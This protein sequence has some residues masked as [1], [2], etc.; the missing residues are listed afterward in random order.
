M[1]DSLKHDVSECFGHPRSKN[2]LCI[3]CQY[4][5]S[6]NFFAASAKSV[7]RRSKLTS[8]EEIQSWLP[9]SAD[10]DHIP[11][12]SEETEL[13]SGLVSM[14][15]RFF[16]YLISLDDYTVGIICAVINSGNTSASGC[17]VSELGKLHGCSR[18]AMHRKILDIIARRPELSSLLQGTMYKL[19]RGRQRFIRRRRE[20]ASSKV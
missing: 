9:E 1:N 15:S 2:T 8:F 13:E 5:Q 6:C 3:D 11:G 7:D 10:F 4:R 14:L 18:Q 12:N 16:R 17:T 20:L 19:S